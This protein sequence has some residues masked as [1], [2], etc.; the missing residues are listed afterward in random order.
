MECLLQCQLDTL[1][2]CLF[3]LNTHWGPWHCL[4]GSTCLLIEM[5]LST[6]LLD[7]KR[8]A[9]SCLLLPHM[10]WSQTTL[11]LTSPLQSLVNKPTMYLEEFQSG[12]YGTWVHVSNICCTVQQ[13]ELTRKK[14]KGSPFNV[15]KS[16]S[17]SLSPNIWSRS[18]AHELRV[19]SQR[20]NAIGAVSTEGL[21]DVYIN[22]K[23]FSI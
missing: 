23:P 11:H 6:D 20:I 9:I 7:K 10:S 21:E 12:L 19:W 16:Y 13:H 1:W 4:L 3:T 14:C 5:Y 17:C 8:S 22:L 2:I 15:V 18:T